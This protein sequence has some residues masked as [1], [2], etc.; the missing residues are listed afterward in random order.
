VAAATDFCDTRPQECACARWHGRTR[1][2]EPYVHSISAFDSVVNIVLI[3]SP[4][5]ST[6]HTKLELQVIGQRSD[7]KY[8]FPL[9]STLCLLNQQL[10]TCEPLVGLA[11][12]LAGLS[13]GCGFDENGLVTSA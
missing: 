2:L 8:T 11:K 12:V 4:Q 7:E 3:E 1:R 6:S 5:R 13:S 9:I 10:P